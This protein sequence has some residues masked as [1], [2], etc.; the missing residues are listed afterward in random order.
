MKLSEYRN[1]YHE[2]SRTASSVCRKLAFAGIILV[3]ILEAQRIPMRMIREELLTALALLATALVFDLLQYIFGT[4]VW[5][6][7]LQHHEKKLKGISVDT[8]IDS[9]SYLKWPE[10]VFFVSKLVSVLLAYYFIIEYIWSPV[11]RH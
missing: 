1:T 8:D 2:A 7:F 11:G 6:V 10:F 3:W 4:I 9:P 5:G